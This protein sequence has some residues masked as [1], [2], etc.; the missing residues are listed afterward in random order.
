VICASSTLFQRNFGTGS[1]F[2]SRV[3]AVLTCSTICIS[4]IFVGYV[5]TAARAF[6]QF[7]FSL[8]IQQFVVQLNKKTRRDETFMVHCSLKK[9]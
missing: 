3:E 9:Q 8:S 5:S 2:A 6:H 7:Q 1:D 4:V